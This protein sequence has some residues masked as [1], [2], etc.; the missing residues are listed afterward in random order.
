MVCS[1]APKAP[2]WEVSDKE[3]YLRTIDG[4]LLLAVGRIL[5]FLGLPLFSWASDGAFLISI[6]T[7][8]VYTV[9]RADDMQWLFSLVS[10]SVH[11]AR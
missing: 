4:S 3:S 6:A 7:S 11:R 9:L 2:L 5:V 8:C 10:A 1:A